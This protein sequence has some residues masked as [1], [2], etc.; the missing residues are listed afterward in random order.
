MIDVASAMDYLHNG[1]STP[2]VHCDL[3]PSNVLLDE[4]MVAHVSDFGIAKMLGAGEAFVQTRTIATIGYIAPGIL[5]L[6]KVFSYHINTQ[7][8]YFPIGVN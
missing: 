3:K 6:F 4:E 2:V 5:K 7:N 8:N 1:Y